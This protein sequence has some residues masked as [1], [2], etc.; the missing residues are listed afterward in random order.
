MPCVQV[1]VHMLGRAGSRTS[2]RMTSTTGLN[3]NTSSSIAFACAG[4]WWS[5]VIKQQPRA[6]ARRPQDHVR[7]PTRPKTLSTESPNSLRE[8]S[9]SHRVRDRARWSHDPAASSSRSSWWSAVSVARGGFLARAL[10][11]TSESGESAVAA[12]ARIG[13][14]PTTTCGWN[15]AR[16]TLEPR[17]S[18]TR[19]PR[20]GAKTV[21][22][23]T[24]RSVCT[25]ILYSP[26]TPCMRVPHRGSTAP[27]ECADTPSICSHQCTTPDMP[28]RLPVFANAGT[29]YVS[30]LTRAWYSA[31]PCQSAWQL[32]APYAESHCRQGRSQTCATM[33]AARGR[34]GA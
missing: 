31:H 33:G 27:S 1:R 21:L 4:P 15:F 9:A 2:A 32:H 18:R 8:S 19:V 30:F 6:A 16:M 20:K 12:A 11:I 22:V 28:N 3:T 13:V 5:P 29:T 24:R 25:I 26:T 17:S 14:S 10:N 34:A 23:S 7:R